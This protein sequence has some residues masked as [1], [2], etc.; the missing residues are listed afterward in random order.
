M[1]ILTL[2]QSTMAFFIGV[3]SLFLVYKLLNIYLKKVFKID[4]INNAY[5]TLQAG[6]V[7]STALLISSIIGPGLNAIRFLNQDAI[8]IQTVAGSLGYV[9]I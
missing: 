1:N 5:A 4:I 2:L 8:T 9:M 3:T 7:L 6:I